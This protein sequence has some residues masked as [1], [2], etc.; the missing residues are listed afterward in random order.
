MLTGIDVW[1]EFSLTDKY[2]NLVNWNG[3]HIIRGELMLKTII[4]AC[5]KYTQCINEDSWKSIFQLL[6][7]V[8]DR[9]FLSEKLAIISDI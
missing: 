9:G 6:L 2:S 5:S 7:W 1:I 8:R 3:A 4:Y